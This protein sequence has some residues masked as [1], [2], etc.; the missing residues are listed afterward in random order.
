MA[1]T[2]LTGRFYSGSLQP[3]LY[4]RL[5]SGKKLSKL[6]A[7]TGALYVVMRHYGTVQCSGGQVAPTF[8]FFAQLNTK[9]FFLH[10]CNLIIATTQ[11][12]NNHVTAYPRTHTIKKVPW[13]CSSKWSILGLIVSIFAPTSDILLN[14]SNS[15]SG[16]FLL[17]MSIWHLRAQEP[18]WSQ[19]LHTATSKC[20]SHHHCRRTIFIFIQI[21]SGRVG[22]TTMSEA[23]PR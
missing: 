14:V 23:R 4:P 17:L 19:H 9:G 1:T 21:A 12:N 20:L 2:Y 15:L 13:T 5:H 6:L 22:R 11:R 3:R 10:H 18:H 7:P 16:Q 8:Y